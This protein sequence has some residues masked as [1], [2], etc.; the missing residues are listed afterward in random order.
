MFIFAIYLVYQTAFLV[1]QSTTV[2][3][4]ACVHKTEKSCPCYD[5]WPHGS[6]QNTL[7]LVPPNLIRI[8]MPGFIRLQTQ[9]S[10]RIIHGTNL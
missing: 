9:I 6:A 10:T 5:T 4:S 2:C 7:Q 3:A 1:C 8:R